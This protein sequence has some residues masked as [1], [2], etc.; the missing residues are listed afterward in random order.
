MQ[1]MLIWNSHS[2][3]ELQSDKTKFK[4][5]VD[6]IACGQV[7]KLLRILIVL[8]G[9]KIIFYYF[10]LLFYL[11]ESVFFCPSVFFTIKILQ[12]FRY[13][14]QR[15]SLFAHNNHGNLYWNTCETASATR[16]SQNKYSKNVKCFYYCS[17]KKKECF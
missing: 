6:S 13:Y 3:F 2:C 9:S 16:I 5:F 14:K 15:W 11:D 8:A 1:L 12:S 17:K 10:F 7:V 4:L